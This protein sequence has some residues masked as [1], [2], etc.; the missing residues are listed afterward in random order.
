MLKLKNVSFAYQDKPILKNISFSLKRGENLSV[1]GE[2]GCGKSTLLKL[3]YGLLHTDGKIFWNDQELQGPQFNIVPGEPF[4]KYLAQDFDLMPPLSV[5]EN[6]GKHLSNMYPR[7]KTN[8]VK[9]LMEV[10]E[11][12]DLA[13][14]KAKH[15]SGGQQQRVA[16]ARALANEPE[17]LLLDEPFSHIDHFRKNNL[18][19]Q[20]FSYLAEKNITCIVATHDST[21]ALS[22]ANKTIVLKNAKI[23]AEGTPEQLYQNPPNKYVAS[24]FGEINEIML[25]NLVV[26][27]TS[28]KKI[29]VYPHEI[30]LSTKSEIKIEIME[31]F[32]RGQHYLIKAK[33]NGQEIFIENPLALKEG[34]MLGIKISPR[35][36]EARK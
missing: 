4:I 6:I 18:R 27:E 21:D 35:L 7:K 19:R 32:F 26:S 14:E 10:V 8:R 31:N 34:E 29:L 12:T 20:V 11:M 30:S 17:L 3:I 24:L 16:L 23:H 15:L 22:F 25:K 33:L 9:E 13:D 28:R 36:I 1:I 5:A 2:S